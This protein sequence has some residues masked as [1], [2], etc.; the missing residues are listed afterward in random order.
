MTRLSGHQPAAPQR[1]LSLMN[2][3]FGGIWRQQASLAATLMSPRRGQ[4]GETQRTT[5]RA[6]LVCV[7]SEWNE[8]TAHTVKCQHLHFLVTNGCR[9]SIASP[10]CCA[11]ASRAPQRPGLLRAAA[12]PASLP[13]WEHRTSSWLAR[14]GPGSALLFHSSVSQIRHTLCAGPLICGST[15]SGG[16]PG[17]GEEE[18][19]RPHPCSDASR[20][21][22]ARGLGSSGQLC[23]S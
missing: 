9:E 18:G 10:C 12:P 7:T 13:C 21:S 17:S 4:Q 23:S 3:A 16:C 22:P 19:A 14:Q 8:H 6:R 5:S 1:P 11:G 20:E 2:P 15:G